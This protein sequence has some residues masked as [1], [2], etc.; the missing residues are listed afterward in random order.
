MSATN[1]PPLN[2]DQEIL[3]KSLQLALRKAFYYLSEGVLGQNCLS[4]SMVARN[5][6]QHFRVPCRVV[7]GFYH[8]DVP[9]HPE[10]KLMSYPHVWV[11]TGNSETADITDLTF[12]GP[13]REILTMGVGLGSS[14]HAVKCRYTQQPTYDILP[15]AQP[16]GVLREVAQDLDAWVRGAPQTSPS[17]KAQIDAIVA[18]A[19]EPGSVVKLKSTALDRIPVTPLAPA[20]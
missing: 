11:Q 20:P 10:G 16:V 3:W 15:G 7:A 18:R 12:S 19:L 9:E 6:F 4:A 8:M 13:F 14:E 2:E 5:I 17:L 1:V